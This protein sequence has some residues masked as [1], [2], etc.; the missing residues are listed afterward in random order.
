M[1]VN[2]INVRH[3][4]DLSSEAVNDERDSL[5]NTNSKV[6][7][8]VIEVRQVVSYVTRTVLVDSLTVYLLTVTESG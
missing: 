7:R 2:T 8:S 3:R 1:L 6:R 5:V 4:C